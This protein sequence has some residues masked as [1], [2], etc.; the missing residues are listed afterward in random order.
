MEFVASGPS[1]KRTEVLELVGSVGVRLPEP[2]V[3][4]YLKSNGGV[5][6]R[7]LLELDGVRTLV[8]AFLPLTSLEDDEETALEVFKDLVLGQR[9]CSEHLFPVASDEGGDYFLVD[10]RTRSATMWMTRHDVDDDEDLVTN[11]KLSFNEFWE[12]LK[13]K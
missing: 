7:K 3:E 1:L 2:V 12:S 4:Q 5:P 13:N 6:A 9:I 10:T 8:G 11:L